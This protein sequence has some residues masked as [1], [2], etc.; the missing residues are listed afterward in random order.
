M[1]KEIC[2]V[3]DSLR[4]WLLAFNKTRLLGVNLLVFLLSIVG[5]ALFVAL[6]V[7]VAKR[8]D[9]PTIA[10]QAKR[11]AEKQSQKEDVKKA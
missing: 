11:I 1:L 7:W 10:D 5:L 8:M 9:E 3:C 2:R 6:I 4:D